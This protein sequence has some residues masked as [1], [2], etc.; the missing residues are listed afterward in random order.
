MQRPPRRS[1]QSFPVTLPPAGLEPS[2]HR[3]RTAP[4]RVRPGRGRRCARTPPAAM[5]G[6]W[7]RAAGRSIGGIRPLW[8]YASNQC[9]IRSVGALPALRAQDPTARDPGPAPPVTATRHLEVLKTAYTT[10]ALSAAAG[11]I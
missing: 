11:V 7:F 10:L 8:T 9:G 6:W 2:T 1:R 5:R 4:D 3:S